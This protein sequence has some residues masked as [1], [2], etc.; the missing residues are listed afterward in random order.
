MSRQRILLPVALAAGL[1]ALSSLGVDGSFHASGA[2]LRPPSREHWFGTDDLGRDLLEGV[3]LGARRSLLVGLG[4]AALA[5][6]VGVGLGVVSGYTGGFVDEALTRVTEFFQVLPRFFV[7]IA[8][9]TLWEPTVW[10]LVL[11]LGLTSWSGLARLT[12]AEA[13]GLREREFVVSARA[14][15]ASFL[16]VVRRHLFPNLAKPLAA[17]AP[18]VVGQAMLTEAGLSF[19]GI[20]SATGV[21]WGYLL[22][23][24]QP[25]LRDA[26]WMA[27]FPGIAI[28][29]TILLLS[30][31]SLFG[32]EAIWI[33]VGGRLR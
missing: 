20:G 25:F 18:I 11:V 4:A 29:S 15:G 32:R 21:S 2:P 22:Q 6:V 9:L 10:L 5:L 27:V 33:V 13:L 1:L 26:P 24:A 14:A 19:L 30:L 31:F 12:R 17:A 7:A 23:N 8:V 28:T 3:V 16:A